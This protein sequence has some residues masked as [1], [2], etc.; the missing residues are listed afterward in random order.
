MVPCVDRLDLE[1]RE[2]RGP[3]PLTTLNELPGRVALRRA[4]RPRLVVVDRPR[5]DLRLCIGH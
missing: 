4:L 3:C 1:L 5:L 2:L